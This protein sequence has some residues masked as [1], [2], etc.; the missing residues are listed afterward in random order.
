MA[1]S[2]LPA[3]VLLPSHCIAIHSS[4]NSW[5]RAHLVNHNETYSTEFSR[6]LVEVP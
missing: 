3:A 4:H 2:D 1:G 5:K 6:E